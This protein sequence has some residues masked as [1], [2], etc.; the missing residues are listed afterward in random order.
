MTTN[1]SSY[2]WT[3]T[4]GPVFDICGATRISTYPVTYN[5]GTATGGT[6]PAAQTKTYDVNLTLETNTGNLARTGYTFAGWDTA[7]DGSGTDYATGGTYTANA[8]VTLY[9]RF[10]LVVGCVNGKDSAGNSLINIDASDRRPALINEQYQ[11][12][13]WPPTRCFGNTSSTRYL[14]PLNT[15]AEFDAFWA[16][17]PRLT[18]LYTIP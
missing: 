6:V 10:T 7:S 5:P 14:I 15:Q 11:V 1:A 17:I 8:T 2:E 18:G 16:A 4:N 9:P 12:T 3:C 13:K